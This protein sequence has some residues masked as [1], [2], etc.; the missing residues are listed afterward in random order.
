MEV[1]YIVSKKELKILKSYIL[2]GQEN[3]CLRCPPRSKMEC[4]GC[5]ENTEYEKCLEFFKDGFNKE[6]LSCQPIVDYVKAD[7]ELSKMH[8]KLM[9]IQEEFDEA[10]LR[11]KK[12]A[13]KLTIVEE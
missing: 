11:K 12:L 9:D 7:I 10:E 13:N 5:Y 4:C 3:P 1:K 6:I 8:E 2:Y